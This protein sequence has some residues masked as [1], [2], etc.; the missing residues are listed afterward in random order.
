MSNEEVTIYYSG[1]KSGKN[2]IKFLMR[3]DFARQ[4][5]KIMNIDETNSFKNR[6][7]C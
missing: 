3:N 2:G 4:M 6:K 5:E 7:E 1:D